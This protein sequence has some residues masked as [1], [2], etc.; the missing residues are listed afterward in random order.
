LRKRVQYNWKELFYSDVS[1]KMKWNK[2]KR[3]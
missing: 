2:C 3:R 1:H